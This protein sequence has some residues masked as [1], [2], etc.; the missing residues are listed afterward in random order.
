MTLWRKWIGIPTDVARALHLRHGNGLYI[1]DI[2][3]VKNVRRASRFLSKGR[4]DLLS[5]VPQ[6]TGKGHAYVV[7]EYLDDRGE[8]WIRVW[9]CHRRGAARQ[10]EIRRY[11][12]VRH[13]GKLLGQY[14]AEGGERHG[15]VEFKNKLL[16]EHREFVR[17]LRALGLPPEQITARCLY[18]P[19]RT[20][21][22]RLQ[23]YCRTYASVTGVTPSIQTSPSMKGCMAAETSVRRAIPEEILL[24]AMNAMRKRLANANTI[25]GALAD[26]RD[27]F[28]AKLLTGDGTLDVRMTPI[29][30]YATLRIVDGNLSYL[31]D[32]H[33]IL[34]ELGFKARLIIARKTVRAYCS[35]E[36]LLELYAIRAFEGTRNWAKLLCAIAI[37]IRGRRIG[38]HQRLRDLSNKQ[39]FTAKDIAKRYHTVSRSAN[40][41]IANMRKLGFVTRVSRFRGHQ[42]IRYRLTERGRSKVELLDRWEQEFNDL[43]NGK[44]GLEPTAILQALKARSSARTAPKIAK[45]G[46][47]SRK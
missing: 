4:I 41:W 20:N 17:A 6:R 33:R 47:S 5:W 37:A 28:L 45:M 22:A 13:L 36:N 2:H 1:T 10:L 35:W 24:H 19:L 43:R 21:V 8:S 27:A 32:Y 16:S 39:T 30:M 15:R 40:L 34:R 44:N 26:F 46:A 9:Y 7:D 29:R 12:D 38:S 31:R 11:I 23:E 18:H 3:P 25:S 14:Q 42:Y